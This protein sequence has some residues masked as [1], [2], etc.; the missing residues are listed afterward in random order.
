MTRRDLLR[1]MLASA[2]AESVDVERLFWTPKPIVTV[3]LRDDTAYI[4]GLIDSAEASGGMVYLAARSTYHIART[5]RL[6]PTVALHGNGSTLRYVGTD[7][8]P[9]IQGDSAQIGLC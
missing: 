4:Q 2:I 7:G 8:G 3:P 5:I 1:L 9:I 6:P